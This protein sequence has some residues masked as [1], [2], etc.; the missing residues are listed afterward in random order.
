MHNYKLS[1]YV[2][3]TVIL[4]LLP[5]IS[6]AS[7]KFIHPVD[8]IAPVILG[9]TGILFFAI[10]GRFT[11]RKFNQPSVLG[12]LIMGIV[13]GHIGYLWGSEFILILRE[14]T[15]V[16]D[17]VDLTMSGES[18]E[19]AAMKTLGPDEANSILAI[20]QGEGG[21][22]L[23]QVAHTVDIFS[24]YGVIFLLF[25]VGLGT[26]LDEMSSVGPSSLRVA[27]AGVVLPFILGF[28]TARLLMP[29]LSIKTDMFVA[30]TLGATSIGITASVLQEMN[31]AEGKEGRIILGAAVMDDILG[32]IMLAIISGIIVSGELNLGNI[33]QTILLAALFLVLTFK[34]GPIYLRFSIALV[35]RLDIIEAKMFISFLF[36]MVLAWFANLVGLATI[37]GA[38]AGGVILADAYFKDWHDSRGYTIKELIMP[39]EVIFAPIFFVLMGVQVKLE[40]IFSIDVI[41]IATGL[42][43][44]AI[45][46]KL[47]S[48]FVAGRGLNRLAIGIGMLPRGEVGLI[49]AS[50]GKTFDVISDELFASIVLMVIVTTLITPPLLKKVIK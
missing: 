39:L 28:F 37:I 40:K 38:F 47:L 6:W 15:A 7:S 8:P 13:L 43:V 44:A 17:M 5:V 33:F 49:F 12:E 14:G 10:M 27:I 4:F 31:K 30:A 26:S 46:G 34:L 42:L 22:T 36:V 35:K 2:S 29:E 21:S 3:Y 45:I 18:L 24:R 25:L 50:I 32:L 11:A 16:F 9:V 19:V 1:R 48:G 41:I 20:L 23:I